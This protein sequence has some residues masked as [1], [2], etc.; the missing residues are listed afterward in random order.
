MRE[1]SFSLLPFSF[2]VG[3]LVNAKRVKKKLV[4]SE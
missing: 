3:M 1:N 2:S 4:S